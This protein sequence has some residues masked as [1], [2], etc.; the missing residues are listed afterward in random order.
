LPDDAGFDLGSEPIVLFWSDVFIKEKF[1][2]L[3][4]I[5]L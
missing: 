4:F 3:V 5:L 2:S 1:C